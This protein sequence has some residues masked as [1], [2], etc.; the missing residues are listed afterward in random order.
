[1]SKEI[2]LVKSF[3]V[4]PGIAKKLEFELKTDPI[5]MYTLGVSVILENDF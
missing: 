1:M 2:L 4:R 5:L 3:L